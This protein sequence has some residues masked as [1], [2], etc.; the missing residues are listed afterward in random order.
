[1]RVLFSPPCITTP[2]NLRPRFLRMSMTP[3]PTP[4]LSTSSSTFDLLTRFLAGSY[5][6][7]FSSSLHMRT[8][9]PSAI[10]VKG[11]RSGLVDHLCCEDLILGLLEAALVLLLLDP[12]G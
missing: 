8:A 12:P 4:V 9:T 5:S 11:V 6:S 1:M 2:V 3:Q 10:C 7:R